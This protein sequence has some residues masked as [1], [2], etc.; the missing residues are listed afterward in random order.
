MRLDPSR[1]Y[2]AADQPEQ[3]SETIVESDQPGSDHPHDSHE[4]PG[5]RH[6]SYEERQTT[7][8]RR[9]TTRRRCSASRMDDESARSGRISRQGR[10]Q[11]PRKVGRE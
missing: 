11:T 10:E 9:Q 3:E 7:A 6:E 2:N 5:N 8:S 1:K 4:Y